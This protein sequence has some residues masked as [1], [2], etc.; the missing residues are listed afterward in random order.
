V[1]YYSSE[2]RLKKNLRQTIED[3][4]KI[5]GAVDSITKL[6]I[7]G[8]EVLLCDDIYSLTEAIIEIHNVKQLC[9]VTNGSH[10]PKS[11][12][13]AHLAHFNNR[14]LI[15]ISGYRSL[16]LPIKEF[17][18]KLIK[19]ELL[20]RVRNEQVWFDLL[21]TDYRKT[22]L[23]ELKHKF[24]YCKCSVD[25]WL[26]VDG[27]LGH[28]CCR[29]NRMF[30]LDKWDECR[31]EVI[32]V[33]DCLSENIVPEMQRI[34]SLEYSQICNYCDGVYNDANPIPPAMCQL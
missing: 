31:D 14:V 23:A 4:N 32:R 6:N 11:G 21:N 17:I 8:G 15:Q 7:S 34:M 13:L 16:K 18:D 30:F 26:Y 27:Y 10:I 9:I 22:S 1:P 28:S 25:S 20:F 29:P 12:L 24:H 2:Q 3:I 5:A 33:S 19:H